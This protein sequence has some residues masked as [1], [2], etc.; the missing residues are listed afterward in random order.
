MAT[1]LIG[2]KGNRLLCEEIEMEIASCQRRKTVFGHTI[3]TGIGGT[4]KTLI[5][6]RTAEALGYLFREK[7]AAA[8]KDR[9]SVIR[10][11]VDGDREGISAGKTVANFIDEAHRLYERQEVF[12]Y[13]MMENRIT[14][15]KG[16]IFFR[17]FTLFAATTHPQK[18]SAESFLTRF[19]NEWEIPRY[20]LSVIKEI[21]GDFLTSHGIQWT[22]LEVTEIAKRSLG[23]PRVAKK[24]AAKVVAK[25]DSR[26]GTEVTKQDVMDV[27][28]V[29]GIDDL[30]LRP[31]H[32]E[33]LA[34]LFAGKGRPRG[35][36]LL[37]AKLGKNVEEIEDRV[38]PILLSLGLI[39]RHPQGRISTRAGEVHL[40]CMGM[41]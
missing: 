7:E 41:V 4:G 17:P 27:F 39:D 1:A 28:R 10:W 11:L 26:M 40:A 13:P 9:E 12:Y 33:Y 19:A 34:V 3:I 36:N 20:E 5:A 38:E 37:A 16:D 15:D 18:L 23:V 25:V 24:L 30:G 8:L 6:K 31:I 14:S 21:I 2:V 22:W 32:R 29:M 35:V